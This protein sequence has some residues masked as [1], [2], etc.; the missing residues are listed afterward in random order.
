MSDAANS[1]NTY[2]EVW[3]VDAG[4]V[5][6]FFK[7]RWGGAADVC[8]I[9]LPER[10]VGTLAFPQTRIV[11]SGERAEEVYHSFFLHFASAGG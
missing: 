8:V 1:I 10:R 2:D 9:A 7:E 5:D 3:A 11:I 4:R 6:S